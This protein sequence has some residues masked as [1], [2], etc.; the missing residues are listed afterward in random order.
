MFTVLQIFG[1]AQFS[2]AIWF[3]IYN[4]R[5]SQQRKHLIQVIFSRPD[6]AV[7]ERQ[8]DAVSYE[9]HM[10]TLVIGRDPRKLYHPKLVE[11]INQTGYN[12]PERG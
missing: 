8:L 10:F 6:W 5:T 1:L 3:L 11:L 7:L 4:H 2:A 12:A 9:R